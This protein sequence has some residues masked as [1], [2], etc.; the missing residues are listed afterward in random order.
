[1]NPAGPSP[2]HIMQLITGGWAAGILGAASTHSVFAHLEDG[3]HN[4]QLLAEK[5]A[6]SPRGAQVLLDGLLGLGLVELSGGAY[7]NTAEA[8]AF[9]VEGR[10]GYYGGFIRIL[11]GHLA[12]DWGNLPESVRTGKPVRAVE[13][14]E[15]GAALWDELVDALFPMGYPSAVRLGQELRRIYPQGNLRILDVAAGSGVWSIGAS[16]ADPNARMVA[17]DLPISL[18]HTRRMAERFGL[19]E[20]YEFR[21][22][23]IRKDTLGEAEFDAAIL[24]HICHSEGPEHTRR[25]FAKVALAL[26]PGGTIAIADFVPDADRSGP[27]MPLLFALNMLLHTTEGDTFTFPEY[28][29]WLREAGFRDARLLQ[30]PGPSPLVLAT[31]A[32]A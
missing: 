2:Q 5:A 11:A 25:L 20:R 26:K 27:P 16:Q 14:P 13:N 3:A 31:R 6:I 24:G 9:L 15:V 28:E 4:A 1:M 19:A 17:F 21:A 10:P 8:E 22:G 7:R 12:A 18:G 30:V 32:G 29:A 23:D